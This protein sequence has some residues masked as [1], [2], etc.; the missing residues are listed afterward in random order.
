M[1][2]YLE[3]VF[4]MS[5]WGSRCTEC[6]GCWH[7]DGYCSFWNFWSYPGYWNISSLSGW[8]R[9]YQ[10]RSVSQLMAKIGNSVVRS[11]YRLYFSDV[12]WFCAALLGLLLFIT[13]PSRFL[14]CLP[15]GPDYEKQWCWKMGSFA[16]C[17]RRPSGL[18][19]RCTLLLVPL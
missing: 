2:L 14:I 17:C 10:L 9:V 12:L 19:L 1:H 8:V 5:A 18:Y 7:E 13:L 3:D 15:P 4:E 16:S 11:R 6:S